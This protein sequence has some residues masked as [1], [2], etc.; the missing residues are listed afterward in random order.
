MAKVNHPVY[1][2]LAFI[3]LAPISPVKETLSFLTDIVDTHNGGEDR[4][5]LRSKP[6]QSYAYTFPVSLETMAKLF[7][8][9]YGAIRKKWALPIWTEAQQVAVVS[10]TSI[11][12]DTALSD[13]RVGDFVY[14]YASKSKSYI[15]QILAIDAASI[16]VNFSVPLTKNSFVIPVRVAWV[17]GGVTTKDNGFT[18]TSEMTFDIIDTSDYSNYDTA[19]N[20]IT[21]V[22]YDEYFKYIEEAPG[23]V[24]DYSD[25]E[26]DDSGWLV[27]KGGFGNYAPGYQ[28]PP[29]NTHVSNGV[30]N[31][32]WIRKKLGF[33]R[34]ADI[35]FNVWHDDGIT[36][37]LN[38]VE[39]TLETLTTFHS[40]GTFPKELIDPN[41]EYTLVAKV[42]DAVPSGNPTYIYV[43]MNA[44]VEFE[45][46][47]TAP[48]SGGSGIS[49]EI[50]QLED[51]IDY[52]TGV[53]ER[54]S[55]WLYA[56]PAFTHS[57]FTDGLSELIDFKTFLLKVQGKYGEFLS[58]SFNTNFR[59]KN[60]GVIGNSL[61]IASDDYTNYSNR[62]YIA[63]QFNDG[64][65]QQ[66]TVSN[67]VDNGNG[68]TTL[69]LITAINLPSSEIARCCYMGV[70]RLDGDMIEITHVGQNC[71]EINFRVLELAP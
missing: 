20:L 27:G 29:A 63:V 6:R 5:P 43:G 1:G 11:A 28:T 32:V 24:A 60:E 67:A 15:R 2:E 58:P 48:I 64:T 3:E 25:P 47:M 53:F 7:N 14:I 70:Y 13:F 4:T 40:V 33:L 21:V 61:V 71:A 45:Q 23:S 37:W 44:V 56:K 35:Y 18:G 16:V 51:S 39:L 59:I 34:K 26:F 30:G 10:G 54:R 62:R 68:T 19:K 12:V 52:E 31:I 42:T 69:S 17:N 66:V 9:Q 49:R 22:S 65:W 41:E 57:I 38:G 36:V 55:T 46:F 8:I 50:S